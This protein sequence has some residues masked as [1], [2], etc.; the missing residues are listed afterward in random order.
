[1]EREKTIFKIK[2]FRTIAKLGFTKIL[3]I[4]HRDFDETMLMYNEYDN[5]DI[6]TII[7]ITFVNLDDDSGGVIIKINISNMATAFT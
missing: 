6:M 3:S 5:N 7:A 1:M 2:L 4:S